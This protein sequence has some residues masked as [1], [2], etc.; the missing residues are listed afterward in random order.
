MSLCFACFLLTPR[1][2]QA[3]LNNPCFFFALLLERERQRMHFFFF[4]PN[5]TRGVSYAGMFFAF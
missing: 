1:K 4:V 2:A 5:T 3:L